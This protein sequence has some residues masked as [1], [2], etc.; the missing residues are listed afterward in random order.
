LDMPFALA[1]D[2]VLGMS[3]HSSQIGG[4]AGPVTH[5]KLTRGLPLSQPYPLRTVVEPFW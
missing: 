1:F 5:G 3:R 4:D 2:R